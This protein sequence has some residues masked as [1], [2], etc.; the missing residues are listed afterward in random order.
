MFEPFRIIIRYLFT[1]FEFRILFKDN[2]YQTNSIYIITVISQC[3][4]VG[5]IVGILSPFG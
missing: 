2:I 3:F 4:K 5:E 1:I